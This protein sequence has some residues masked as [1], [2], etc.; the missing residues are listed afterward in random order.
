[1]GA[2]MLYFFWNC[3]GIQMKNESFLQNNLFLLFKK[4][5]KI[6]SFFS[7]LALFAGSGTVASKSGTFLTTE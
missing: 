3:N 4:C 6:Y 5:L 1:M 7:L 2:S